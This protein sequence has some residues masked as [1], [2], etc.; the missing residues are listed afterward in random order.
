MK[1]LYATLFGPLS[2]K[3]CLYF[4]IV[5][6]FF[7]LMFLGALSIEGV[8]LYKNMKRLTPRALVSGLVLTFNMFI[9][10]FVNRLL[11]SMCSRS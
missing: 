8:W 6:I 4:H 11:Y 9:I 5:S 1:D 2:S 10:Y 7:F 3:Y